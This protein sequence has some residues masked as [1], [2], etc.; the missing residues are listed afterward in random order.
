MLGNIYLTGRRIANLSLSFFPLAVLCL[1]AF[2]LAAQQQSGS[3]QSQ[4]DQDPV[5][6]AARKAREKK[7]D[8]PKPKKVFDEDNIPKA[9]RGNEG[10]APTAPSDGQAAAQAQGATPAQGEAAA[11]G[12]AAGKNPEET[13]RARFKAQREKIARA[14]K[15]LD[16]LQRE[17]EKAQMQYYPDPQK[18]LKEQNTRKEINEKNAKIATKQKEIDAL[19]QGLADMEDELRKSGGDAGWARE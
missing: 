3:Q 6:E 18:A 19:K 16:I 15:E 2:P 14:E 13:W 9:P 1:M 11:A 4:Q 12:A 5:A 7:K 17:S 10:A 8:Q